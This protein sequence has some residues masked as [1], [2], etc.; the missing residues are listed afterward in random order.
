MPE[1]LELDY[2]TV[3]ESLPTGVY[4]VDS[5]RR[6]LFWND[7]AERI[8]GYLRLEAIGRR[9]GDNLLKHCDETN[10]ILC[11][12]DCPLLGTMRDG[13]RRQTDVFLSHK[14]GQRVPVR[15]HAV[16]LRNEHGSL[17]GAVECFDIREV[18]PAGLDVHRF[19]MHHVVHSVAE[20]P[21]RQKIVACLEAEIADFEESPVPFGVLVVRVDQLER[22]LRTSGRCAVDS[23]SGVVART[24]AANLGPNDLVGRWSDNCFVVVIKNCAVKTLTRC[25]ALLKGLVH[26]AAIPWW[27]DQLSVTVSMGGTM[28]RDGDTPESLLQRAEQNLDAAAEAGG[29]RIAVT[30]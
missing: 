11:G 26:A 27:G 20:L 3:L 28:M 13:H 2:R 8:T 14:E 7:G 9:C 4:V 22:V 19:G 24:L 5:N 25:A 30:D 23:V 6:I 15:V 18:L 1:D 17:V 16:P 21:D 29:D 12:T 10:T